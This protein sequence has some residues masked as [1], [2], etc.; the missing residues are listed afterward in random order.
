MQRIGI[1]GIEGSYHYQVAKTFF[2]VDEV[3]INCYDYFHEMMEDLAE[4]VID[5]AVMAI[6]N[7]VAGTLHRNYELVR[8]SGCFVVG[9]VKKR[10]AHCL[11]ALPDQS[12]EEIVEAHSHYMAL[13]QCRVFFANHPHIRLIQTED[14]AVAARMIRQQGKKGVAA[15][16]SKQ[17]AE[18]FDLEILAE[19]IETH[20][21][22]FTR[23]FILDRGPRQIGAEVDKASLCFALPHREGSLAAILG[24]LS[25]YGMNMTKIE[26]VPI[27]GRE[28]QYL[29]YVDIA[30]TDKEAYHDALNAIRPLSEQ[31][32]VIGEYKACQRIE[33]L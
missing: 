5:K 19:E 20:K 7:T 23:F 22:N 9:E 29:F 11:L 31:F 17:S 28:W 21:K 4:G 32:S 33:E 24:I 3:E 10:I 15:V 8:Q 14:T 12:I 30:F 1:Q 18:L 26:S 13:D 25:F 16:A 27:I 6:E 2:T